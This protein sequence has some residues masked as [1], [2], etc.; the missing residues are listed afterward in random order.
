MWLHGAVIMILPPGVRV[1]ESTLQPT[2]VQT[3]MSFFAM[4]ALTW[5]Q[6]TLPIGYIA[7]VDCVWRDSWLSGT[8]VQV[9]PHLH[10]PGYSLCVD[11]CVCSCV[12]RISGFVYQNVELLVYPYSLMSNPLTLYI[13]R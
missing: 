2:H 11:L 4:H 5:A 13:K 7:W 6:G 8:G 1:A 3:A 12:K 10:M 9:P